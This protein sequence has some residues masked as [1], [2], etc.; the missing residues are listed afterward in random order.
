MDLSVIDS[1][2][3]IELILFLQEKTN[4][5]VENGVECLYTIA[6]NNYNENTMSALASCEKNRRQLINL[7]SFKKHVSNKIKDF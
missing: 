7:G 2:E 4:Y 5:P 1:T 6:D 3:S